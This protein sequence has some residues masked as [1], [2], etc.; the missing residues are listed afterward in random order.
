MVP[1]SFLDSL[2]CSA[3]VDNAPNIYRDYKE[4]FRIAQNAQYEDSTQAFIIAKLCIHV[5][6]A[7][8][9][10]DIYKINLCD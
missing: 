6:R 9:I 7:L 1:T 4:Q 3:L 8:S 5:P 10:V 2:A